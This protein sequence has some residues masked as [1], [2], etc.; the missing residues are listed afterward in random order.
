MLFK[1][2]NDFDMICNKTN[3]YLSCFTWFLS[4]FSWTSSTSCCL[5]WE[6]SW[7][8]LD[9]EHRKSWLWAVQGLWPL[10]WQE[11]WH[12]PFTLSC[13][14]L[15]HCLAGNCTWVAVR[16]LLS[17][18][19]SFDLGT[20]FTLS[21]SLTFTLSLSLTFSFLPLEG[22]LFSGSCVLS[23]PT[24]SLSL[25]VLVPLE[26]ILIDDP[27]AS[28][29]AFSKLD[30][31]WK[32]RKKRAKW[33]WL[34]CSKR[35]AFIIKH[36]TD[37]DTNTWKCMHFSFFIFLSDIGLFTHLLSISCLYTVL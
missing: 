37:L 4:M 24:V 1:S 36:W 25:R 2:W 12:C 35:N 15:L 6:V 3:N 26:G 34:L 29:R 28:C 21:L 32:H 18:A 16:L 9:P 30:R 20:S 11:F 17:F 19:N 14:S 8:L 5:S 7:I 10:T 31:S 27:T 22:D 23:C 33:K 13:K